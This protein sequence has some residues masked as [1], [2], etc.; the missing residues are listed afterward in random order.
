MDQLF[1]SGEKRRACVLL[2][3]ANFGKERKREV[4][5]PTISQEALAEMVVQLVARIGDDHIVPVSCAR[6]SISQNAV[7]R[8]DRLGRLAG[9]HLTGGSALSDDCTYSLTG[10]RCR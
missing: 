7:S 8:C 1:N 3:L 4:A 6:A 10:G 2:L 5:I 9:S